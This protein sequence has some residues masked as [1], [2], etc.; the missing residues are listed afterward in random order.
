M[1]TPSRAIRPSSSPCG[2][3]RRM[4]VKRWVVSGA[5]CISCCGTQFSRIASAKTHFQRGL[6]GETQSGNAPVPTSPD[7]PMLRPPLKVVSRGEERGAPRLHWPG[8]R[9]R[10]G[11]LVARPAEPVAFERIETVGDASETGGRL[12]HGDAL[13]VAQALAGAGLAGQVDL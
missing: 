4:S 2:K 9:W 1:R 7:Q 11:V 10:T 3:A 5:R 8:R 13:V 6:Q 12:V